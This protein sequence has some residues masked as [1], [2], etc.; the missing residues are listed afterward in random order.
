MRSIQT[1]IISVTILGASL[2]SCSPS[3][4][5]KDQPLPEAA[6]RQPIKTVTLPAFNMKDANGNTVNL[7]SFSGR[8][9]FVNLWATWCPPCRAEIPSIERL[10][11][12]ADREHVAFVML[13]LDESFELA[14]KFAQAQNMSMP[15]YYPAEKLPALFNTDGIPVTFIFDENGVLVKQINGS[16]DYDTDLYIELLGKK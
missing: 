15:V 11:S 10:A 2:F 6:S 9:V 5:E 12:K 4:D 7:S 3:I 8:K 14:K 16:D 13:S 1:T